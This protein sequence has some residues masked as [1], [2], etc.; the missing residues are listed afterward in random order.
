MICNTGD[1][2]TKKHAYK[3]IEIP[4]SV[5]CLQGILTIIP[6][7]LLSLH[8]AQ[9]RKY[10]VSQTLLYLQTLASNSYAALDTKPQR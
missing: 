2:E 4:H 6:M 9:L 1:E 10:D 7:Q 8:I 5:D 3:T